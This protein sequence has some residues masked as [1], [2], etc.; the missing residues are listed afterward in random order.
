VSGRPNPKA[1]TPWPR[2]LLCAIAFCLIAL[3]V[4]AII[5]VSCLAGFNPQQLISLIHQIGSVARAVRG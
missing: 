4:I 3:A 1:P 2:S 5:A